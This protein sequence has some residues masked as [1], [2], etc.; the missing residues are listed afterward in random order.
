M[1]RQ[2]LTSPTTVMIIQ[3]VCVPISQRKR[4]AVSALLYQQVRLAASHLYESEVRIFKASILR[5]G[6][7]HARDSRMR[8]V[9]RCR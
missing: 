1:I 9:G 6:L 3:E 2:A 8:T 5:L 7:E 4:I